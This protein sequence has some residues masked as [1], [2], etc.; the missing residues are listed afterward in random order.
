MFIPPDGLFHRLVVRALRW[1]QTLGGTHPALEY[2]RGSFF[3]DVQHE[4]VL[5]MERKNDLAYI[6]VHELFICLTLSN[7]SNCLAMKCQMSS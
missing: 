6:Q 1:S 3:V 2:Y 5:Q 7:L 4:F